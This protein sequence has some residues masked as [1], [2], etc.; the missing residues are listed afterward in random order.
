MIEKKIEKA[1]NKQ[2]NHELTAAYSYMAMAAYFAEISLD[3]FATFM[4]KQREEETQHANRLYQYLLDRDGKVDLPPISSPKM[5]F[6]GVKDVFDTAL[7]LEQ[8]NTAAINHV[9]QVAAQHKDYAT[10]SA[11]QWFLDEQVEEE[12]SMRDMLEIVKFAGGDKGAILV[13]NQQIAKGA[14]PGVQGG[15][16]DGGGGGGA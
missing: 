11:L 7:A 4:H 2:I 5:Q 15:G 13:L 14:I 9:Y 1:I 12:K 10:L 8:N 3:G 6:N 16:L